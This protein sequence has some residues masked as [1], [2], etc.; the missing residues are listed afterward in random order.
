MVWVTKSSQYKTNQ[1]M[2]FKKMN[3][4]VYTRILGSQV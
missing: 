3:L 2:V 4:K 1:V